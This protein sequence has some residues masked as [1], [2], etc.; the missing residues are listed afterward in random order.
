MNFY[1]KWI[2]LIALMIS[3]VFSYD[4]GF[5]EG[6]WTFVML[7]MLFEFS[8]WAGLISIEDD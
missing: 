1:I 5:T 3:A 4:Y 2:I 6:V 7:G 8:F